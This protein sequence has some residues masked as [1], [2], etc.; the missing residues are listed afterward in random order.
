VGAKK[1]RN[2]CAARRALVDWRKTQREVKKK[3][4]E[5]RRSDRRDENGDNKQTTKTGTRNLHLS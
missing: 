4:M 1:T 3:N 2:R 5:R